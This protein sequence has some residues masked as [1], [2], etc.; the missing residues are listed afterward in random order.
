MCFSTEKLRGIVVNI[1]TKKLPTLVALLSSLLLT[2][3]VHAKDYIAL[4]QDI[5]RYL[6]EVDT[7][8]QDVGRYSFELIE[9]LHTLALTQFRAN[10]FS[11]A[12]S[13]IDWAIQIARFRDGLYTPIQHPLQQTAIEIELFSGNWEKLNKKLEHYAWLISKQ[14][15][16]S[17][18]SQLDQTRW[19]ADIHLRAFQS[20]PSDERAAHLIK[21]T[22]LREGLVQYAQAARLSDGPLYADLLFELALAYRHEVDAIRSGGS[23]SY[24]LRRLIPGTDIIQARRDAIA[25]R[26]RVGLEK[27]EM[28]L[29]LVE[30]ESIFDQEAAVMANLYIADWHRLFNKRNAHEASIERALAT[31]SQTESNA[32]TLAAL[33]EKSAEV[34][35]EQLPP[36]FQALSSNLAIAGD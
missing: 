24:Q 26:Y 10:L 8:E 19:L 5:N 9:P 20:N 4:Q 27:L 31:L 13:S 35:W 28:L 32:Q 3:P 29:S 17:T 14:Q 30:S 11:A 6:K 33:L 25:R 36:I 2:G 16:V 15:N 34:S 21:G 23:T 18:R 1:F 22:Y 12:E 7:I